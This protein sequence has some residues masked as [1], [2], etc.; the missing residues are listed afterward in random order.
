MKSTNLS[1]ISVFSTTYSVFF[2]F[3]LTSLVALPVAWADETN[4]TVTYSHRQVS[5]TPNAPDPEVV[6]G[7]IV[8]TF[9]SNNPIVLVEPDPTMTRISDTEFTYI[10]AWDNDQPKTVTFRD[11][12]AIDIEVTAFPEPIYPFDPANHS[13]PVINI[14]TTPANLWDPEIGIYVWG[15]H[16]NCLQRGSEW[17]RQARYDYYDTD[18]NLAISRD[19]GIRINGGYTRFYKQKSLRIYFDHFGPDNYLEYDFFGDE[20]AT[21]KRTLLRLG[22][23]PDQLVNAVLVESLFREL[24]HFSSRFAYSAVYLNEEFW[25]I[26][27]IR[28][29]F[30][31]E[32]FEHTYGL[33]GTD[34]VFLKDDTTEHGD[35]DLW[36]QFRAAINTADDHSSHEFFQW[37]DENLDLSSYIDWLALNIFGAPPDNGFGGNLVILKPENDKWQYITWDEDSCFNG[38]NLESD[39]FRFL[40][41]PNET[42]FNQFLPETYYHPWSQNLQS[43]FSVF[44][45]LMQ[46]AEFR[47][48]FSQ[49]F[50][51]LLADHLTP[52]NLVQRLNEISGPLLPEMGMHAERIGWW[53]S[54]VFTNYT[55]YVANWI[56]DRHINVSAHK[57]AFMAHHRADVELSEFA[58]IATDTQIQLNW[59]TEA[60]TDNQGFVIYRSVGNPNNMIEIASYLTTPELVGQISSVTPTLYEFVDTTANL[61]ETNYYQLHH[62]NTNNDVTVHNWIEST[63]VSPWAGLVVNEVMANNTSTV[64][65]NFGE[66]DDWVELYNSSSEPILLNSLYVTDDLDDPTKFQLT[67]GLTVP[68]YGYLLLWADSQASTQ[69]PDHCTFS[70]SANGEEFGIFQ[71]DGQ[72]LID[73]VSFNSQISDVSYAR[74]P[75]ATGDW[76]YAA[77]VTVAT[78]NVFP[79]TELVLVVNEL[80]SNNVTTHTDEQGEYD[81]WLEIFNPLPISVDLTGLTLTDDIS[82]P[83]KWAFPEL[84]LPGGQHLVVWSDAEAGQGALHTNF[85]LNP[86]GGNLA[87]YSTLSTEFCDTITYPVLAADQAYARIPDGSDNLEITNEP[88]AGQANPSGYTGP[89]LFI[90]EFMAANDNTIADE[91]GEFDDWLEIYNPGPDPFEIGGLFITDDLLDRTKWELPDTTLSPGSHLLIWCDNDQEQGPWHTDF[92]LSASG[93]EIGLFDQISNGNALIDSYSFGLQTP[94]I[95]EG[96]QA[97]GGLPWVFFTNPTP[98]ADNDSV[99]ASLPSI[100]TGI[101][102][103]PNRPNPF[104]PHTIISFIIADAGPI[105]LTIFDTAG[106]QVRTLINEPM[107]AGPHAQ[108]WD[109]KNNNGLHVASGVYYYRLEGAKEAQTKKMLLIK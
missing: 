81:P 11:E 27:V 24:G 43:Y 59:R 74:Y 105:R 85:L 68:A 1:R 33:N 9:S 12:L 10:F 23:Y 84:S 90:N 38:S 65:D 69:G 60:E 7:S 25:G 64:T 79:S 94:D 18:N 67:G 5:D 109:G 37:V 16:D 58:A 29:R 82:T 76:A 42:E 92:K 17:E 99:S 63:W 14:T 8:A 98:G 80:M 75:N 34:Y 45:S 22:R 71:P 28:E 31:N 3:V 106:R 35:P 46:N 2:L 72:T 39:Y 57:A 87:L 91:F 52:S 70:L 20:P 55:N 15:N 107:S 4:I 56:A 19:V 50:D 66:Y 89:S 88:S 53:G 77:N 93:E 62:V 104:N 100:P 95:S 41:A 21:F 40:S 44:H 73:W 6:E 13:V 54:G 32:Y 78:E 103:L 108:I 51:E 30:D 48:L 102:L 83:Q 49:R 101:L 61:N 86:S 97:D 96:R 36:W 47:A 26:E